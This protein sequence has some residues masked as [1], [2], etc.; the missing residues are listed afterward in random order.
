VDERYEYNAPPY[1]L[2]LPD[3]YC[4]YPKFLI[5]YVREDNFL[6]LEEA[7]YK[8]STLPA[9]IYDLKDRGTL[10]VGAYADITLL[11]LP[12][13]EIVG[14]PELS[15]RYPKGIQ[16]VIING[17]IV[18]DNGSHTGERPGKILKRK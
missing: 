12:H 10:K 11:D 9:K 8:C 3:V 18:V 7:V 5:R 14:A 6:T 2:P 16:H 17:K 15:N 13:L 4:G 1:G